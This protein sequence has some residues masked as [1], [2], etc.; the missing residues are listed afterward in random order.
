[1]LGSNITKKEVCSVCTRS[2]L[3]GQLTIICAN[4]DCI[5]HSRCAKK[6]K[7]TTFREKP[8]CSTCI[9]MYDIIRYNPFMDLLDGQDDKFFEDQPA[10]YIESI[11]EYSEMLE[12]SLHY[13]KKQFRDLINSLEENKTIKNQLFSTYFLN[14]DGN[15]T[16]FEQLNTELKMLEHKFSVVAIAETNIDESQKD[17]F[18]IGYEYTSIY[19]SKIEGKSKGSG[20]GIYIKNDLEHDILDEFSICNENIECKFV[21]VSQHN[22]FLIVGALYRP[23]S[24]NLRSFNE[25]LETIISKLPD[26]GCYILG[27]YNVN[28][29]NLNS[30]PQAAFEELVISNGYCPL[31]PI[32]TNEQP[33]CNKSCIDNILTNQN[34]KTVLAS[35]KITGRISTHSGIFQISV[36]NSLSAQSEKAINK[37]KIEYG[38][39][40]TNLQ[41]FVDT[42]AVD[43]E[44]SKVSDV[45]F[46][47]F[48]QVFQLSL[49]KACKLDKPKTTKRNSISNPWITSGIIKSINTNDELY[50]NWKDS[51]KTMKDGNSQILAKQKEHQK[52]LR[53]LIKTAKTKYYSDKFKNVQGDKKKTWKLIN[54]LRGKEKQEL[55]PMFTIDNETIVCR[56]VIANK[57]N[58]YF[59]SLASNLNSKAY[60]D[61]PITEFPPFTSYL[62]KPIESSIFLED[63]SEEEISC[64]IKEL[65]TGKSSDI[66]IITIKAAR[67]VIVPYLCKLYNQ[68]MS[69]G[70]FPDLLK[71]SKITPVYKKGNKKLIENY[72]PVAT[73]PIF[74]K[75]FEKIIYIRLH[76]FLSCKGIISDSQFGFRKEHST[77]HAIHYSINIIKE[78]LMNKKHVLGIFIDLSKAFD[79]LDHSILLKKLENY[80]IRGI[81]NDLL[82]SY[83][84]NRRQ[85]TNVLNESSKTEPIRYK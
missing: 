42:L 23:P 58:S 7:F 1:M 46:D 82:R 56:R 69:A 65:Q 14:I 8:Y 26:K 44:A 76:S 28:L 25:E 2:I 81:A 63:C 59:A 27:D 13:S 79:T 55:K 64:I 15:S 21:K 33:G 40:E 83:L 18:K 57:F 9:R 66:P 32:A 85:Y 45:S 84:S 35:G 41:K 78:S 17:L 5:T 20:L 34:P 22:N 54:Q 4:C 70:S 10:E 3:I 11:Q 68:Y 71:T 6:N 39:N 51:F 37:V 74:G 48:S 72:R 80:G 60:H 52:I 62:I 61:I 12:N 47:K 43:L 36:G 38:Y 19:Q 30:G 24:G 49:D 53:W 29:L 50:K 75:I 73:I 67:I 31:I 77:A 16:N